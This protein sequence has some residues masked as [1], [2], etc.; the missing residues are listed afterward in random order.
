MVRAAHVGDQHRRRRHDEH[1]GDQNGDDPAAHQQPPG[2]RGTESCS[3]RMDAR[4]VPDRHDG[5]LRRN[6]TARLTGKSN[7]TVRGPP[8]TPSVTRWQLLIAPRPDCSATT[9]QKVLPLP[10]MLVQSS[11]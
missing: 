11:M 6:K 10:P 1:N 9:C 5:G 8:T 4:A 3:M 7:E 2:P